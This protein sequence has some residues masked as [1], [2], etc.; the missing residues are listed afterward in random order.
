L[1]PKWSYE[2][3]KGHYVPGGVTVTHNRLLPM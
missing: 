2:I 3:G 1:G